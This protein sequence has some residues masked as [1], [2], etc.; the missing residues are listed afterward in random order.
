MGS[1]RIN[2]GT[3]GLISR[4]SSR[5]YR[6]QTNYEHIMTSN[7]RKIFDFFKKSTTEKENVPP[8]PKSPQIE[9]SQLQLT[10]PNKRAD[11]TPK[12]KVS[13]NVSQKSTKSLP[14]QKSTKP[15]PNKSKN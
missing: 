4:V 10:S 11:C 9:I 8:A 3:W 5:T 13:K 1:S 6:K 15:L 12:L 14:S 2:T 7:Q